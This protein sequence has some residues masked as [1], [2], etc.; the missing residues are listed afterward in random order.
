[1]GWET[2]DLVRTNDLISNR[3]GAPDGDQ[4]VHNGAPS[5]KKPTFD[6]ELAELRQ[7]IAEKKGA[8][9]L[10]AGEEGTTAAKM[11]VAAAP[12]GAGGGKAGRAKTAKGLFKLAEA[13]ELQG[14][15][16]AVL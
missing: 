1:M 13:A 12:E 16:S 3:K 4:E 6:E 14:R 11:A 2:V 8:L 10:S 5:D 7:A 15:Y 9:L